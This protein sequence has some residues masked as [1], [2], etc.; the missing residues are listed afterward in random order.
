MNRNVFTADFIES[1]IIY[2]EERFVL[3]DR[4]PLNFVYFAMSFTNIKCG[5]VDLLRF[6][7]KILALFSCG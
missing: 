5:I 6:L 3:I 4:Q 2:L 1:N 7:S